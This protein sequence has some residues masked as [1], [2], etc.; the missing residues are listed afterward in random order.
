[1]ERRAESSKRKTEG[2]QMKQQAKAAGQ[3]GGRR[4]VGAERR[5]RKARRRAKPAALAH[6]HDSEKET[7]VE[8]R[9]K[10]SR[11]KILSTGCGLTQSRP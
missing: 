1:M 11:A 8:A 6:S 10:R 7:G 4:P 9:G 5:A 2:R 3:S